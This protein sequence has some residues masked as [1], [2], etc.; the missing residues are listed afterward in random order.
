MATVAVIGE[1]ALVRAW[2]LA[3]AEVLGAD[4]AGQVREAWRTL[5]SDVAVVVLTR[6][7]ADVLTDEVGRGTPLTVVFPG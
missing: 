7:A 6:A 2:S 1:R 5:G 4:D 3:G